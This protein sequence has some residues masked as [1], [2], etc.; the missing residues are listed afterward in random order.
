MK[1]D[2][3]HEAVG[4]LI[5]DNNKKE[6]SNIPETN[7][8]KLSPPAFSEEENSHEKDYSDLIEQIKVDTEDIKL[9]KKEIT[10]TDENREGNGVGNSKEENGFKTCD[11]LVGGTETDGI[12]IMLTLD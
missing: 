10:E 6:T 3:L 5:T 7:N 11:V 9:E 2:T 12:S 1:H 8:N 4:G